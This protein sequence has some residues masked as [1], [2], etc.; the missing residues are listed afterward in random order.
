M[1][2]TSTLYKLIILYMLEKVDFPLT[3]SQ[4]S[5]FMLDKEYTNYFK[6]QQVI[7]EMVSSH[8]LRE[9]QV[10]SRTLY[11]LTEEGA[12]TIQFFRNKISDAI[13]EDIDTFLSEKKYD[14]KNEVSVKSDYYPNPNNEFAVRCQVIEHNTSLIDLTITVPTQREAEAVATNWTSKNQEIYAFVMAQLLS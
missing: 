5:E 2:E 10:H 12:N 11:H 9:E 13:R 14:L 8:L 7:S 3:N 6:L 4:I 1:S